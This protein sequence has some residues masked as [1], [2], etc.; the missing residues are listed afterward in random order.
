MGSDLTTE[1]DAGV[2]TG[3]LTVLVAQVAALPQPGVM[4]LVKLPWLEIVDPLAS[5]ALTVTWNVR[6]LVLNAGAEV[7]VH[8]TVPE[9]KL[10]LQFG[11][12]PQLA[13]PAT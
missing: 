1:I 13:E 11:A 6:L 12:E 7:N 9:A 4:T 10:T 5:P 2:I 8:V 3:L